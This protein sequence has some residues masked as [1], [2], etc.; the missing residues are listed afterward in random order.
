MTR[1]AFGPR[2]QAVV[3]YLTGR[4]GASHRDVVEAMAALYGLEV[5]AGSVSAIQRQVSEALRAPVEEACHFVRQQKSQNVDE[6][7]WREGGHLRWLWVNATREVTACEVLGGRGA[8][9]AGRV[10]DPSGRSIVTTDR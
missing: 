4:L 7:G 5:S 1:G 10:V 3:A 8:D 9:E 6:T 2:A